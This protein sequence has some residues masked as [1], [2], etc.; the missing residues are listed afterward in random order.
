MGGGA[1]VHEDEELV[2]CPDVVGKR[3]RVAKVA[4]VGREKDV[5]VG[6]DRRRVHMEVVTVAPREGQGS[7]ESRLDL[8]EIFDQ[9]SLQ[10]VGDSAVESRFHATNGAHR[11]GDDVDRR[12]GLEHAIG[13]MAQKE[14]PVA[15][16]AADKN[17]R[18]DEYPVWHVARIG[19]RRVDGC[20]VLSVDDVVEA[21]EV[22][23]R[24][25]A[26][27]SSLIAQGEDVGGSYAGM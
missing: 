24:P 11:F 25:G 16:G 23:N 6:G 20:S 4:A 1:V 21:S 2:G 8:I 17:V 27:R 19:T 7:V 26:L 3:S 10:F 13:F 18:V 15:N 14:E 12:M 5:C 22:G 9:A